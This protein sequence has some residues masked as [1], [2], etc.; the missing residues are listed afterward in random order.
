MHAVSVLSA[1]LERTRG[2]GL[3]EA[4]EDLPGVQ[5][6]SGGTSVAK[7]IIRGQLGRRL[8]LLVDGIKHESQ[9][10]GLDRARKSTPFYRQAGISVI[11]GAAAVR[12]GPDAIGGVVR[13]Y[14][15]TRNCRRRTGWRGDLH[16]AGLS[17]GISGPGAARLSW[18]SAKT[19]VW[20]RKSKAVSKRT[21]PRV[22]PTIHSITPAPRN[23]ME[24]AKSV[25]GAARFLRRSP[26]IDITSKLGVLPECACTAS[27]TSSPGQSRPTNELQTIAPISPSTDQRDVTHDQVEAQTRL[28]RLPIGSVQATYSFQH[29][30]RREYDVVRQS[31]SGAQFDF[32]LL[33][34]PSMAS[35]ITIQCISAK[36]GTCAVPPA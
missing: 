28:D 8:T 22:R 16:L 4:L 32:R 12:Y 10:W 11:R 20:P 9:Q 17:D 1:E 35:T 25:I 7:P 24:A 31:T 5:A 27:R 14:M 30:L 26:T 2:Q 19:T 6:L 18:A 36:V 34:T 21:R 29:D 15:Y 23:G 3:A 13:G 33:L